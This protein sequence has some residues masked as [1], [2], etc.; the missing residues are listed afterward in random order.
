[1]STL[2]MLRPLSVEEYLEGENRSD[3]KHEFVAGE[4]HAMIGTSRAH[5]RI[6]GRFYAKLL[7]HLD[8]TSCSVFMLDVK[9]RVGDDFY[10]PDLLVACD[11]ADSEPLFVTC[12]RLVIEVLSPGT[13]TRDTREK[14][15]AYQSIE[16]LQEYVLAEQERREVRVYRRA[17]AGWTLATCAGTAPVELAS[18]D[19]TLSLDDIYG[20]ILP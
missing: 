10:Y 9:L 3:D 12:P 2:T 20:G 17:G 7:A 5:N 1:M 15:V 6:A 14:L 19:L 18:L 4:V 8:G 16:S 13:A 11:P